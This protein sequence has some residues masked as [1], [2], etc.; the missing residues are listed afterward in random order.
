MK[1]DNIS[2]FNGKKEVVISEDNGFEKPLDGQGRGERRDEAV[3][4]QIHAVLVDI[5]VLENC[6]YILLETARRDNILH[7]EDS[8]LL[9]DLLLAMRFALIILFVDVLANRNRHIRIDTRCVD[10]FL[11]EREVLPERLLPVHLDIIQRKR[12]TAV[13]LR[14]V[15]VHGTYVERVFVGDDV[16]DQLHGR[17]T[18]ALDLLRLIY[19]TSLLHILL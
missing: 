14:R 19:E 10:V 17:I 11:H 18:F 15:L 5:Y 6:I 8:L 1:V 3:E 12:H 4:Q 9:Q 2:F 7:T 13:G 16:L